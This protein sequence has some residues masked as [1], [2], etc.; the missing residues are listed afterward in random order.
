[1]IR[2]E[3]AKLITQN[4]RGWINSPL[5]KKHMLDQESLEIADSILSLLS[6]SGVEAVKAC[7][8]ESGLIDDVRVIKFAG[9]NPELLT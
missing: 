7:T 3:I 8:C 1:M 5:I 9:S 2:D 4:V 6:K